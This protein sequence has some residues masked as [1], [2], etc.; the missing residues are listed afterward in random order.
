MA[1]TPTNNCQ[2]KINNGKINIYP[3]S[4]NGMQFRLNG[5][6]RIKDYV[7][8]AIRERETISKTLSKYIAAF[9][10]FDKPLLVLSAASV[11]VSITLFATVT[12]PIGIASTSYECFLMPLKL[13][14]NFS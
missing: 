2:G 8:D 9:E 3:Q 13:L 12:A 7:I 10:Y 11:G 1:G 6:K 5:I 4:D 14:K